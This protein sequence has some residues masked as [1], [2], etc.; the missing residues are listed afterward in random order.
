[1]WCMASELN[2]RKSA[3]LKAVVAVWCA[4]CNA[5]STRERHAMYILVCKDLAEPGTAII[6][7]A[8]NITWHQA[9][10]LQVYDW[11]NGCLVRLYVTYSNNNTAT[12]CA[13]ECNDAARPFKTL[14]CSCAT[15]LLC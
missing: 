5:A 4:L 2:D 1:M 7:P 6:C 12:V 9:D 8:H 11:V 13:R 10:T 14:S 15:N 3:K